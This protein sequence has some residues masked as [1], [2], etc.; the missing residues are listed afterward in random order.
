MTACDED[1]LQS[2]SFKLSFEQIGVGL[3]KCQQGES[4]KTNL[5][6]PREV[7]LSVYL[8]GQQI[9]ERVSGSRSVQQ[10]ADDV[11][12]IFSQ[13]SFMEWISLAV[14]P[15]PTSSATPRRR[16]SDPVIS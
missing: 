7:G 1:S 8:S 3:S 11:L 12:K 14:R 16:L 2:T 4:S 5:P 9:E 13:F 10:Q 15:S 6:L